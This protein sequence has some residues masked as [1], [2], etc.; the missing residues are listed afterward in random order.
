MVDNE[1]M[2]TES[3]LRYI[4]FF[5]EVGGSL[6]FLKHRKAVSFNT[7]KGLDKILGEG[8]RSEE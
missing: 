6:L 2:S 4:V 1:S 3:I 5:P 7:Y 8:M